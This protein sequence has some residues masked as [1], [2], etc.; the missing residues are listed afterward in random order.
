MQDYTIM[1]KIAVLSSFGNGSLELN[2]VSWDGKPAK[3]DVRTW[4]DKN[5]NHT[6]GK[7]ITLS[8]DEAMK[9]STALMRHFG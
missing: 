4:F 3:L 9:L 7:G 1:E 6:P 5:G 2:K 8:D